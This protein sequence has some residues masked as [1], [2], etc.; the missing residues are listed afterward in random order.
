[1]AKMID[2]C[3]VAGMLVRMQHAVKDKRHRTQAKWWR[4]QIL[5]VIKE[6]SE[7][8]VSS[9]YI[10]SGRCSG[11]T[12]AT[13]SLAAA[14]LLCSTNVHIVLATP[15]GM[16][17]RRTLQQLIQQYLVD[18][19]PQPDTTVAWKPYG[20]NVVS[21]GS[22]GVLA[23]VSTA[24]DARARGDEVDLVLIDEYHYID[25]ELRKWATDAH[26][27]GRTKLIA[28]GTPTTVTP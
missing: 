22:V 26:A 1:M 3:A 20:L 2:E 5:T 9:I 10:D 11:K 28:V 6:P 21:E 14:V 19:R 13:A 24:E 23:I 18:F 17:S 12:P 15:G 16:R 7:K 8:S 25:A 4:K 27:T